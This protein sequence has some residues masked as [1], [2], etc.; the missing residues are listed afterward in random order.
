M[1]V[2][3]QDLYCGA[4]ILS[5]GGCLEEARITGSGQ[6]PSVTF[7]LSGQNVDKLAREFQSGQ[8]MINLAAFKVAMTHLKDVMFSTLRGERLEVRG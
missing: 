2:T 5:K 1:R 6:R 4:Y 8:A 3:T 7:I